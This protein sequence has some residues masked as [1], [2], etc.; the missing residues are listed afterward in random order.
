[1]PGVP[2]EIVTL[3]E[4]SQAVVLLRKFYDRVVKLPRALLDPEDVELLDEAEKFLHC[5]DDVT[6]PESHGYRRG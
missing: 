6:P 2:E 5:E 4:Q 3:K 1:V